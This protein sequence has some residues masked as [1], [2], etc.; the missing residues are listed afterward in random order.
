MKKWRIL[1]MTYNIYLLTDDLRKTYFPY[2]KEVN[3]LKNK[4][5]VAKSHHKVRKKRVLF[6]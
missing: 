1:K 6:K 2:G 3:K 5:I 4:K